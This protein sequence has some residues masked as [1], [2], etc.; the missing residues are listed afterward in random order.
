MMINVCR[1]PARLSKVENSEG[2]T[3]DKHVI[4]VTF[5]LQYIHRDHE[6]GDCYSVQAC[7]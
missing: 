6:R 4:T 1:L 2:L 5:R 3:V 7:A